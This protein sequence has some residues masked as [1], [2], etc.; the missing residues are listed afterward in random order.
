L[1]YK[2]NLFDFGLGELNFNE[3]L[4]QKITGNM[5]LNLDNGVIL[6]SPN[7]FEFENRICP[8]CGKNTLNKKKFVDCEVIL[9]KI[10]D[11]VLYFK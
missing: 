5:D 6:T 10:G 4:N 11:A 9:D 7:H 1:A 3:Q 8:H 2:L